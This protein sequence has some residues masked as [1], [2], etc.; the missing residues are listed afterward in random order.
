MTRWRKRGRRRRNK[1]WFR[2][3]HDPR[4]HNLSIQ[5]CRKGGLTTARRYL[6]TGRWH[7]DWWDRCDRR[8]R[9][10]EGDYVDEYENEKEDDRGGREFD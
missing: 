5:D 3:G 2:K 8:T 6:C 10:E 7:L 4:R 1:G 9:N